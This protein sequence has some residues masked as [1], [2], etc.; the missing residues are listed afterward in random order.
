MCL[1]P[2]TWTDGWPVIGAP[3]EDGIGNMVWTAR[4]PIAGAP[5]TAPQTNDDFDAQ[6][7]APQWAWNHHPRG[8]KWSLV[9]RPGFLRLHAFK[10]LDRSD[11]L[12]KAG[13]TI[14]Q[15]VMRTASS[16]ATVKLDLTA[17]ADGQRA[18]L[19]HFARTYSMFGVTQSG[20]DR[21][22][23]YD[24]N[25]KVTSGP[26]ITGDAI[27][28]RSSWGHDGRSRY[29]YSLDGETFTD[30]GGV[31][32]LTWGSYRGDRIGV[33]SYNNAGDHGHVDVDWFHH[34]PGPRTTK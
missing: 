12:K 24:D 9:E 30:F 22:L 11:N 34:D 19:C 2:I 23:T 21:T 31:Y 32:Q 18:G 17:L 6:A 14:S 4:K 10:T 5:V 27:W 15:R 16:V 28:L 3:G 26:A 25:G 20:K 33:Y 29:A 8:E 7:L 13:N 1:L